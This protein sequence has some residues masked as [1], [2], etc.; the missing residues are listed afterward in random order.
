[1]RDRNRPERGRTGGA[2]PSFIEQG[3]ENKAEG[4]KNDSSTFIRVYRFS[5]QREDHTGQR[6]PDG[7]GVDPA[8]ADAS[9]LL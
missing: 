8:R 2:F 3:K 7:A 9:D 4:D 1:M 6:D 5:G